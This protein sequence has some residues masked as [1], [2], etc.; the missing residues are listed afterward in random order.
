MKIYSASSL[1]NGVQMNGRLYDEV[2][3]RWEVNERSSALVDYSTAIEGFGRLGKGHAML[4]ITE[5]SELFSWQEVQLLKRY[6]EGTHA[7]GIQHVR[8]DVEEMQL[9]MSTFRDPTISW[10]QWSEECSRGPY[11]HLDALKSPAELPEH[12]AQLDIS[13]RFTLSGLEPSGYAINPG[14]QGAIVAF[15]EALAEELNLE[16][17]T[18]ERGVNAT[19]ARGLTFE[20][21]TKTSDHDLPF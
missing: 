6:L 12:L 8:F 3:I 11:L 1:V 7:I 20:D 5:L 4:A 18:V 15:S 19:W 13:G 10:H 2:T 17:D 14:D 21:R 16:R 9:P